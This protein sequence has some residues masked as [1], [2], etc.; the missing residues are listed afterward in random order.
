MTTNV[1]IK[2]NFQMVTFSVEWYMQH[3]TIVM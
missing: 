3:A 2:L 1:K